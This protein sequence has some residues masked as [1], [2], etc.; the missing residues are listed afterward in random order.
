MAVPPSLVML[1]PRVAEDEV[2]FALVG[3]V[4]VG[5]LVVL[6]VPIAVV[7]LVPMLLMAYAHLGHTAAADERIVIGAGA[8]ENH[9]SFG[10]R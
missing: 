5:R 6:K 8:G 2:R 1:P 4:M 9:A 10:D 7:W 3:E